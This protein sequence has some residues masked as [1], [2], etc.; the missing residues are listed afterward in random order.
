MYQ[1]F[2]DKDTLV[3]TLNNSHDTHMLAVDNKEDGIVR[4]ITKD[5]G[6]LLQEIQDEEHKRNRQKVIEIDHYLEY[7]RDELESL[8][9]VTPQP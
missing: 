7:Q 5:S 9:M 3:T 1:L 2:V 4:R 6:S 8:E